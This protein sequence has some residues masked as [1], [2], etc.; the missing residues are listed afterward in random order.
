M[1]M[2]VNVKPM[3]YT[4]YSS[5][6]DAVGHSQVSL[7]LSELQWSNGLVDLYRSGL[8]QEGLPVNKI[9]DIVPCF[10][11][12]HMGFELD[13]LLYSSVRVEQVYAS[14]SVLPDVMAD[15]VTDWACKSS[16][17]ALPR[18]G[19]YEFYIDDD[20]FWGYF[21]D[22]DLDPCSALYYVDS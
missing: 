18:G 8:L 11:S 12:Q 22:D 21:L 6:H 16:S 9:T 10:F 19:Q 2:T 4:K 15:I 1:K 7:T 20:A 13:N 5:R 17:S 3:V 14:R